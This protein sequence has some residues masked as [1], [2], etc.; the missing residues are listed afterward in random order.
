VKSLKPVKVK[1]ITN[2]VLVVVMMSMKVVVVIAVV[3]TVL[4]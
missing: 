3:K 2:R 1:V 4:A